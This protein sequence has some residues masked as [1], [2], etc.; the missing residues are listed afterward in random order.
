MVECINMPRNSAIVHDCIAD[1]SGLKCVVCGWEWKGKGTFP[2]RNCRAVGGKAE[3]TRKMLLAVRNTH[4]GPG[5]FLHDAILHWTGEAPRRECSCRDHIAQMNAWGPSACREHIDEIV[6]W[7]IAEAKKRNWWHLAVA[8]PGSRYFIKR[9]VL[10]AIR[11]TEA[12]DQ[13][14][15]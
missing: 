14:Y 8:I 2:N 15:P 4:K 3:S 6:D 5:D 13:E 9:M 11:K 10:T 7:L 12:K 1:E